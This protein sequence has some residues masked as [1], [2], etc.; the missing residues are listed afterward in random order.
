MTRSGQQ[1]VDLVEGDLGALDL[2]EDGV[3]ALDAPLHARL[4]V[5]FAQLLDQRVFHAAQK[6]LALD[7][8]GLDG[9]RHL[10]V[11]HRIGVAEGQVF[12]L[13]AHLAHAQ[14]VRQRS[15]DVQ[16]L[17]GNRFLAIG[18]QVLQRAHVVQA[19]GQLDEDH[20]HIGDHGQQHLANVFSLAVFAVGKLDF[21]DLGNAL[22]DVRHLV[23]ELRLDLLVG[24]RRVFNR[25]VQQ[26]GG[27]GRRV[28]LHLRQ[29][30]GHFQRVDD[31]GL[32]GGAHLPLMMLDAELPGLANQGN[33]FAG[34]IGLDLAE[35]GFKSLIDQALRR[36]WLRGARHRLRLPSR[37][38]GRAFS[39]CRDDL[40]GTRHTSL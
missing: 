19:V 37:N 35:Q 24:G 36:G 22:D 26:A 38:P 29:H 8:P 17:A 9:R 20:A 25:I 2:L 14:A 1:I 33:I 23:A 7:A 30:L 11:A 13:A 39:I 34:T 10:L 28:H 21:V 18:L 16:G 31:V 5:V 32:A 4:D 15:V 40:P 3:E 12:E 27:N 6:L